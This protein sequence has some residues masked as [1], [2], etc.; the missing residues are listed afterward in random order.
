M[1]QK[2][3]D[4]LVYNISDEIKCELCS[5][6]FKSKSKIPFKTLKLCKTCIEEN[7][8]RLHNYVFEFTEKG[9]IKILCSDIKG[10]EFKGEYLTWKQLKDYLTDITDEEILKLPVICQEHH[11]FT[12]IKCNPVIQIRLDDDKNGMIEENDFDGS[13]LRGQY[14]NMLNSD[15]KDKEGDYKLDHPKQ[16]NLSLII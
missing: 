15:E 6:V 12:Y 5:N 4:A 8:N 9:P 3:V 1:P 7:H 10:K 16:F 11:H 2:K 13:F 14:E